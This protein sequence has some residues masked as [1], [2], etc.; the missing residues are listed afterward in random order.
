MSRERGGRREL[1]MQ[2]EVGEEAEEGGGARG[3]RT[4][5]TGE[6]ERRREGGRRKEAEK[7]K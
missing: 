6:R 5:E 7:D 3:E 4:L 1:E 2:R